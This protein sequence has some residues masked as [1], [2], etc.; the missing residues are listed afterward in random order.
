MCKSQHLFLISAS[1][2]PATGPPE[3]SVPAPATSLA[4]G[5]SSLM[6][7]R[8]A[9]GD[10]VAPYSLPPSL[11]P[12]PSPL[13][14]SRTP[15][16]SDLPC[17]RQPLLLK[18]GYGDS[19]E[20]GRVGAAWAGGGLLL[21]PPAWQARLC[22]VR[23]SPPPGAGRASSPHSC[24][25]ASSSPGAASSP[26]VAHKPL[27]LPC[28]RCRCFMDATVGGEVAVVGKRGDGRWGGRE[29]RGGDRLEDATIFR[30]IHSGES[31]GCG[32]LPSAQGGEQAAAVCGRGRGGCGG[33]AVVVH[34]M[35]SARDVTS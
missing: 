22:G 7:S 35:T 21:L 33:Q 30:G 5:G 27:F 25:A 14:R 9:H 8:A 31:G 29:V 17:R 11:V 3:I 6:E 12:P 4:V 1:R 32:G 13:N 20:A 19:V 16:S 10:A 28:M 18:A 2:D 24:R 26:P 34:R 15:P 23:P